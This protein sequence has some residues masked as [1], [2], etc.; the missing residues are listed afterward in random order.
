MAYQDHQP[1]HYQTVSLKFRTSLLN[2]NIWGKKVL[3]Q[4]VEH[5]SLTN[6]QKHT[7]KF[8]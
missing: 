4:L 3:H 7:L 8:R 2:V 5:D 1:H 6:T